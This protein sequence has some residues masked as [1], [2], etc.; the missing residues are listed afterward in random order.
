MYRYYLKSHRMGMKPINVQCR[1]HKYICDIAVVPVAFTNASCE[2]ALTIMWQHWLATH[3]CM[4]STGEWP[5]SIRSLDVCNILPEMIIMFSHILLPTLIKWA[6]RHS[7][8]IY[9]LLFL[10][11]K[12]SQELV[13][14]TRY[15]S[16]KHSQSCRQLM[17]SFWLTNKIHLHY[18][19][20]LR[21]IS[22][23][24]NDCQ[25]SYVPLNGFPL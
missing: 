17:T 12:N 11:E 19:L 22:L 5:G 21:V 20:L 23:V 13:L 25:I 2:R 4:R 6:K 24:T 16:A 8:D 18:V 7:L 3:Y 15:L 1:T 10:L 9:C 14:Q